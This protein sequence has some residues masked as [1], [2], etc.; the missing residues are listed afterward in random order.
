MTTVL[1]CKIGESKGVPRIWLEGEKLARAGVS[2]GSKY[3]IR[4]QPEDGRLELIPLA[5]SAASAA[6][7][8][9]SKRVRK[10][11]IR[12]LMEIRTALLSSLFSGMEKVRV[13][14]RKGRI[15]VTAL[16]IEVMIRERVRRLQLKLAAKEKLNVVSLFHGGGVRT[17]LSVFVAFCHL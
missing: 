15:V 11:I 10:G 5:E 4:E 16:R 3:R 13:A 1:T 6:T 8:K 7:C 2:I 17:C 9:V 12:P 14:I